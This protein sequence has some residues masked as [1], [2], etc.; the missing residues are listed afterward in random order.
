MAKSV[1]GCG[2]DK[3]FDG[4]TMLDKVS[5]DR[6]QPCATAQPAGGGSR[7]RSADRFQKCDLAWNDPMAARQVALS[8]R[9]YVDH[10]LGE[11]DNDRR[12]SAFRQGAALDAPWK[13]S[14]AGNR[15]QTALQRSR[16][17]ARY[18]V[19][20]MPAIERVSIDGRDNERHLAAIGGHRA[21]PPRLRVAPTASLRA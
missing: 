16:E 14:I 2:S 5:P 18:A 1:A 8:G 3:V 19:Q 15:W 6:G 7:P 9:L 13:I 21:R 12:V 4:T 20:D 10:A 17:P 11:R